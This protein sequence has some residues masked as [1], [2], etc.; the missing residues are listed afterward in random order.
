M[1]VSESQNFTNIAPFNTPDIY[2]PN[3]TENGGV[4]SLSSVSKSQHNLPKY[5]N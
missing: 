2:Y 4:E 5:W 3:Y 1:L